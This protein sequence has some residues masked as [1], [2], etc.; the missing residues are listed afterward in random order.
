MKLVL[1]T[2]IICNNVLFALSAP[3]ISRSILDVAQRD[4]GET[5][6]S[7]IRCAAILGTEGLGPCSPPRFVPLGR[8]GNIFDNLQSAS[9]VDGH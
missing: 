8:P 3:I 6:L 7:T 1:Y 4:I 9:Q 5:T 2:L